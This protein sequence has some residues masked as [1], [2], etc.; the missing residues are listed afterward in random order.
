MEETK[1]GSLVQ[2]LEEL[3]ERFSCESYA[4]KGPELLVEEGSI[5]VLVSAP[6]AVTQTREGADK[7]AEILTGAL[8]LWLHET[9]GVHIFCRAKADGHDPN[10]DAFEENSYQQE[11]VRYCQ[12][13]H[14]SC[15]VDLHGASAEHAFGIDIG[16]ASTPQD[17]HAS[18]LGHGFLLDLM[19][20]ALVSTVGTL[21][22]FDEAIVHDGRFAAAGAHTIARNVSER[23]QVPA[24]QIEVNGQLRD[25]KHPEAVH[26]LAEGLAL[27]CLEAARWDTEAP[28]PCVMQLFQAKEQ[29]PRDVCYVVQD[30]GVRP[31]G[32]LEICGPAGTTP[33]VHVRAADEAYAARKFEASGMEGTE[34]AHALFLPNRMTK[35]LF[36]GDDRWGLIEPRA[37]MPVL[38]QKTPALTAAVRV[39][40]AEHVDRVY[41]SHDLAAW[42]AEETG[43][44]PARP[45]ECVL[46]SRISDT[47]LVIDPAGADYAPYALKQHEKSV[48]V[49]RYFKALLGIN[50]LPVPQI[51]EEE[52]EALLA[53]ADDETRALA[54]RCYSENPARS[55]PFCRLSESCTEEERERLAEAERKLGLGRTLELMLVDAPQEK[56]QGRLER[57][58]DAF[59][60]TWIGSCK[61]WLLSTYA[62]D[63]DDANNIARLSPDLMKLAG[64]EDNDRICVRFG[65]ASAV[66]RVLVDEGLDDAR[67]SLPAGTRAALG[68]DSVNDVVTVEREESHILRRSMDLQLIALLGTVIAVFQLELD[69]WLQIVICLALF[70][71]ISWA[72][73]NEER[74][75]VR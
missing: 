36:A 59:L 69:L 46:Y 64:V 58:G 66:L 28:D 38:V 61:L 48:Y 53:E 10:F 30:A 29:L 13:H 54:R 56:K 62:K 70:P 2:R 15:V 12:E 71:A 67:V 42:I 40:V 44:D 72:A 52:M 14:V 39:P 34:A 11:L 51:R 43:K 20:A 9:C 31:C 4:G 68:I 50:E 18:L 73:L 17:L 63:E 5:P 35:R 57:F 27:F 7:R 22:L 25:V 21:S 8:A 1:A 19:D 3:E 65:A 47:Q 74:V 75:K 45:K 32:T 60:D 26:T 49:P 55:D 24:L 6:H 16:T 37:G 23:A 33:L 41:V